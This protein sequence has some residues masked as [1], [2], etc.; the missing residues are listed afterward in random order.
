MKIVDVLS[1]KFH[2]NPSIRLCIISCMLNAINEHGDRSV[3]I[4]GFIEENLNSY[5]VITEDLMWIYVIQSRENQIATLKILK[6]LKRFR[7]APE[8]YVKAIVMSLGHF[9]S[10]VK[11]AAFDSFSGKIGIDERDPAMKKIS[12]II[13]QEVLRHLDDKGVFMRFDNWLPDE[14]NEENTEFLIR[15][16]EN[17]LENDEKTAVGAVFLIQKIF[18]TERFGKDFL[19]KTAF[20]VIKSMQRFQ[21][22]VHKEYIDVFESIY[23]KDNYNAV[24]TGFLE[25]L[26]VE[27]TRKQEVFLDVLAYALEKFNG[28]RK[29]LIRILE[30]I[31]DKSER[32]KSCKEIFEVCSR[33][34]TITNSLPVNSHLLIEKFGEIQRLGEFKNALYPYLQYFVMVKEKSKGVKLAFPVVLPNYSEETD[35][36]FAFEAFVKHKILLKSKNILAL[37]EIFSESNEKSREF[38]ITSTYSEKAWIN[39]VKVLV[40]SSRGL[41]KFVVFCETSLNSNV[42]GFKEIFFNTSVMKIIMQNLDENYETNVLY[43]HLVQLLSVNVSV[44]FDYFLTRLAVAA[45]GLYLEKESSKEIVMYLDFISRLIY[46]KTLNSL[47]NC[48]ISADLKANTMSLTNKQPCSNYLDLIL[49]SG[50]KFLPQQKE[51]S[52]EISSAAYQLLLKISNFSS[53]QTIEKVLELVNFHFKVFEKTP[54]FQT[55]VFQL[56]EGLNLPNK[57][58]FL[59][60]N[61]SKSILKLLSNL[62]FSEKVLTLQAPNLYIISA[63]VFTSLAQWYLRY[64]KTFAKK[65]VKFYMNAVLKTQNLDLIPAFKKLIFAI[66]LSGEEVLWVAETLFTEEFTLFDIIILAYTCNSKSFFA[67]QD[68]N[69]LLKL[70]SKNYQKSLISGL[71]NY[72]TKL[73]K[74]N[75]KEHLKVITDFFPCFHINVTGIMRHILEKNAE[76]GNWLFNRESESDRNYRFLLLLQFFYHFFCISEF[77]FEVTENNEKTLK[78]FVDYLGESQIEEVLVMEISIFSILVKRALDAKTC[79]KLKETFKK[80]FETYIKTS[81]SSIKISQKIDFPAFPQSKQSKVSRFVSDFLILPSTYRVISL[82]F[83]DKKQR[84]EYLSAL[85]ASVLNQSPK[86]KYSYHCLLDVFA[87]FAKNEN[88]LY[89]KIQPLLITISQVNNKFSEIFL[90]FPK[91]CFSWCRA[92]NQCDSHSR[93]F[94]EFRKAFL[95]KSKGFGVNIQE[96]ARLLYLSGFLVWTGKAE[97][98]L[99]PK[100]TDYFARDIGELI[101]SDVFFSVSC[102]VLQVLLVKMSMDEY[103]L[104]WQAVWPALKSKFE[105]IKARND[106]TMHVSMLKLIDIL[107]AHGFSEIAYLNFNNNIRYT[108]VVSPRGSIF[109]DIQPTTMSE[110]RTYT[111]SLLK[112]STEFHSE[113]TPLDT[114]SIKTSI[115]KEFLRLK[116]IIF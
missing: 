65:I 83:P 32:I 8:L 52:S 108:P 106:V 45:N 99:S 113:L 18:L 89:N 80:S 14:M 105:E 63:R 29:I 85:F 62:V 93:L 48:P 95:P 22:T 114:D 84:L 101:D 69:E 81:M 112:Q 51:N 16:I 94:E 43:K 109:K 88:A 40:K 25:R 50:Y 71:M 5:P 64:D 54:N 4:R 102:L 76:H 86:A 74:A 9:M 1:Q 46:K 107:L 10:R 100:I 111:I 61:I 35:M 97:D 79:E 34:I 110:I 19:Q 90:K 103:F 87:E 98:Y 11:Q 3:V 15:A 91:V 68:I 21:N 13:L 17:T 27:L 47:K 24:W 53:I 104:V 55:A 12:K 66:V 23:A 116:D 73:L 38:L 56:L 28:D 115:N 39:A 82:I 30:K 26:D 75:N 96:K 67:I 59:P 31:N 49:F 58:T 36:L 70:V 92:L 41:K 2:N 72:W 6:R 37:W 57:L 78:E 20:C 7:S 42:S 44:V 60:E 33:L 77:D